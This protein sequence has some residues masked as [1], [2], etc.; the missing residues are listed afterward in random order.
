[1][2]AFES[3][4]PAPVG[5]ND[6]PHR[7]PK[8]PK[9][10]EDVVDEGILEV[11]D[12]VDTGLDNPASDATT[13]TNKLFPDSSQLHSERPHFYMGEDEE[14]RY[15]RVDEMFSYNDSLEECPPQFGPRVEICK[16]KYTSL[17]KKW[18]GTLIIKLM[19]KLV[20]YR[21]LQQRV[22]DLWQLDRGFELTDLEEG[23]FI[24]RFF[25]RDDYLHVLEGGP[26]IILGY[27]LTVMKC[28]PKFR[29][30]AE[31]VSKTLIWV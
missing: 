15:A 8:K 25:T 13:W 7:S 3:T 17:F 9:H 2:S 23:Y 27:Y 21:T 6:P 10:N 31:T 5:D 20:S 12:L 22:R 11:Q 28:R 19:G 26:W 29:P 4:P 18:W 14:E 24:V 16:E 1:M 30:V